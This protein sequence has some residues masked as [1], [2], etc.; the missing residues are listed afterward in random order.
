MQSCESS[1]NLRAGFSTDLKL[2]AIGL[3]PE[4]WC[5]RLLTGS[6]TLQATSLTARRA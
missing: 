5:Q 4:S 6:N 3:G 2:A 1:G